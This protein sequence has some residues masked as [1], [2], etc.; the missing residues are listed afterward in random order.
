MRKLIIMGCCLVLSGIVALPARSQQFG[1]NPPSVRWK[2]INTDSARIIFQSGMDS[3]ANRA[4][5]IVHYLAN[6]KPVSLGEQLK[7]INIVLQNQ[8]TIANGYVGLGPFRSEFFMTPEFN[9][10]QEGSIGWTDQLAVHEYRHV[11]QFNNFRNGISKTMKFLFGE[12]GFTLAV[13]AAIPDWFYEG[14]A[15]YNETVLTNQ[16]RGRLPL[17]MNAYPSLWQAGKKYSWM[18]LR[19]GSIKDYVPNHYYLGYLL[20]NYG[21]EKYGTDFWTKVTRDASAYKGLL[22]PFQ[23]A[24][25]E[26]AGV[27]YKTF[28]EQ[29]FAYYKKDAAVSPAKETYVLPVRKNYVTNYYFP[30]NAGNDS[31]I[32]LKSS[33]RHRPA[34]YIKDAS[35]EH[36]LRGRDIST[37]EQ[38]SYRNGKIVYA[39]YENDPRWSWRDYSV[40]KVLDV[41][42]GQQQTLT[43]KSKYFTPDISGDGSR[44]AAVQVTPE[45]RS[46]LHV[47]DARNGQVLQSIHSAEISLF[48]DPKFIDENSLVTAVRLKDGKMALA[49]AEISTG[50]TTRLTNPSFNVVGYPCV[51]NGIIYF[52]ANYGGNDDVFALRLTDRK[53]FKISN[54]PL[55]NYFV[56]A[57][58]GKI[59]WSAFTAEGYQLKQMTE[60]DIVWN[61]VEMA[62]SDN[63]TEKF[64]VSHTPEYSDI[65]LHKVPARNFPVDKYKKGTKLL[66]L[67]S[68]RPY[69]SDPIFTFS[70]YGENVL[71]T[72][73]TELYYLYNQNDKTNAVGYTAVYGAWFPYLN[74][75][76]EFTFDRE[77]ITGN[78]LRKWKQ[79]DSRIGLNVPLSFTGGQTYK[80][81]NISSFYVRRNEFNTGFFKDSM[82]NTSF[83]YL[84][85]SVSW[86]QQVQTAAQHIYPRFAYSLFFGLRH[87]ITKFD[88]NQTIANG[89]LYV[90]GL[91][92]THNLLLTA[93]IQ[94]R[95]TLSEISFSNRFAYSRGYTGRYFSRMWR[96]SAN[97]HLPLLY[98]DWGF[99]NILYIQRL[100]ANFFYDFTK[101]YSRDKKSTRDQRSVGGEI[102][103]DT[104]WWNQY[105]LTFGFRISQLLDI[106]Q[107]DGF[108]GTIFEFVLPV[109]II[110]R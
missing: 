101:V 16:G 33:Y 22:Y 60:K 26:Y 99:G 51:N 53:I 81:F 57:A 71:N 7:K 80:N 107:F 5:A 67:H 105:P 76:T 32:Y 72:L 1:G 10:F 39:A 11:Q 13:N 94:Q 21:R 54:G 65:L 8:T 109:S 20:V 86:S 18:K 84:S 44:I 97:Y 69:Y 37:D 91:L 42:T 35:G 70:V 40:I 95:D 88:G 2:Q 25:K 27:D 55:G 82:G 74:L 68:W 90:P 104:K 6:Q 4:A 38:F 79:L 3:Q 108:K 19:N 58:N 29:A 14:D 49:T 102:F 87:A 110:P 62:A 89:S 36:K 47:L 28:R 75:G 61:E 106:D 48:T 73:Q 66:N 9:N 46:E 96:L 15:V 50:N 23:K 59:S 92:S 43:K 77:A 41:Q 17:F 12:D 63:L 85:H 78:K 24:V 30:Y 34:F 45:G 93:S 98:P 31:L 83:S 100:R 103:M 52:T 64:T 56:N